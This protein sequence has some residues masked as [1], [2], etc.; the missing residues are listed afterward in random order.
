MNLRKKNLHVIANLF[1]LIDISGVQLLNWLAKVL[2]QDLDHSTSAIAV[3]KVDGETFLAKAASATNSVEVSLTVHLL[4]LH[5]HR[6]IVV[7]D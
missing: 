5:V 4:R 2:L 6:Q 7:D 3:D 1:N